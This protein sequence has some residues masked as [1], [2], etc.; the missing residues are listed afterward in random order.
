MILEDHHYFFYMIFKFESGLNLVDISVTL[1]CLW[2]SHIS[3][4]T[5]S[6]EFFSDP[7][8]ISTFFF[9]IVSQMFL[10]VILFIYIS[11]VVPLLPPDFHSANLPSHPYSPMPL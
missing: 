6:G 7:R 5:S 10:L 11:N 2:K 1:K 4:E 8:F 9:F 3:C